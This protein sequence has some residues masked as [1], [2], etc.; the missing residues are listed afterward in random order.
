MAVRL[1]ELLL[2]EK[3]ITPTQ[4]QEALNHQKANGGKLGMTLVKLGMVKDEVELARLEEHLLFCGNC[5]ERAEVNAYFVDQIR[6]MRSGADW[7][8]NVALP[9]CAGTEPPTE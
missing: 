3:R 2:R 7:A 6:T 8:S 1:G 5:I 9:S 4:L